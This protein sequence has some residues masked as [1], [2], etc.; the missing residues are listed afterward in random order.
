MAIAKPKRPTVIVSGTVQ[1]IAQRTK[2]ETGE[3]YRHDVTVQTEDGSLLSVEYWQRNEF[4]PLPQ[5]LAFVALVVEVS[6][7]REYGASLGFVR[8]LTEGDLDL[9][10]SRAFAG[11]KVKA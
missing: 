5:V 10:H 7:S 9:L 4:V 1:D 2:R 11:D 3:V 8:D 6:E